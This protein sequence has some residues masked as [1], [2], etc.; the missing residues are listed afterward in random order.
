MI[1]K[2]IGVCRLVY[3]LALELKIRAYQSAGVRLSAYEIQKELKELR[4]EY[5]WIAEVNSQALVNSINMVDAAFKNFFA[6]K[7]FP[8]FKGKRSGGSFR[9]V[10]NLRRIDWAKSTLTVPKIAAIPITLSRKFEGQIRTV[11]ISRTP[12]GKYFASVLVKSPQ[13]KPVLPTIKPETTVGL[14]VGV[15]SFVVASTGRSFDANRK[16]K[17]SMARL[18]CLQRRASRKQKGSNNRKKAKLCV[19]IL[20]EKITN[21]RTDYIHKITTGLIRDNQAET[22]VIESLNVAGMLRNHNLAQAIS[23]ASF[24]EFARQMKY[25]CEWYGKNLIEIGVF[26]PSSKMCSECGAINKTLTLADREWLCASCGTSHERDLNAAI[27]IRNIGLKKY[28]PVGSGGEPVESSA[29]A[30]AMKHGNIP[31]K[32]GIS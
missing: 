26:E 13:L 29:I 7:G 1:D 30:E 18:K 5:D 15:K 14:D 11:T 21:Q 32:R 28:S 24:G 23:D 25:K 12:S 19:A 10:T 31:R 9:C 3:N 6:G 27:N 16:L 4:K 2:T 17:S 20:H 22:F 8:K